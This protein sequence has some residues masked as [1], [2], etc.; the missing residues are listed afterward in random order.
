MQ[1][2]RSL[3]PNLIVWSGFRVQ[4]ELIDF[5]LGSRTE[6]YGISVHWHVVRNLKGLTMVPKKGKLLIWIA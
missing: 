1:F 5:L 3:N 4:T 2:V 6:I